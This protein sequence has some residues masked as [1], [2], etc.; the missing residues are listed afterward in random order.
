[1]ALALADRGHAVSLITHP[2]PPGHTPA[3]PSILPTRAGG[4]GHPRIRV[5]DATDRTLPSLH[6]AAGNLAPWLPIYRRAVERLNFIHRSPVIYLPNILGDSYG[7]GAAL[8]ATHPELLRM[9]AWQHTD[10]DYDAALI[11]RYAPCL[12]GI[13]AIDQAHRDTL[14]RR[15]D[16][17]RTLGDRIQCI[18]HGVEVPPAPPPARQPRALLP[19]HLLYTGRIEHKQKRITAL[20]Y[21]SDELDRRAVPHRIT[22]IG[23]GPARGD[24]ARLC[25]ERRSLEL[26]PACSPEQLVEY[27][28]RADA[29]VL[30]S[31]YEG[32]C[33]SR[34]EAAAHGCVPIVTTDRSGAGEGLTD[35]VSA[36]F[37]AA[38]SDDDEPTAARHMADA[39][40]RFLAA[41]AR[42]MAIAAWESARSGFSIEAHATAVARLFRQVAASP[43]RAWPSS[44]SPAFSAV[45]GGAGPVGAGAVTDSGS[46]GP[47]AHARTLEVLKA[48]AERR[49]GG[50]EE[51]EGQER[52]WESGLPGGIALHG[53]GQHTIELAS[54]FARSPVPIVA[55]A[56][57]D[58]ERWGSRLLGWP[59][60]PPKGLAAMGVRDV[61]ISSYI[62]GESIWAKRSVYENAGIRVSR[63]YPA[64]AESR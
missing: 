56:D 52:L 46:L 39:V 54:V 61:V 33:I 19:V 31:R 55:V 11:D 57:D 15:Y 32:L 50:E 30:P 38:K 3:P 35:G 10:S 27:Y 9:V 24:L 28:K 51:V 21:L 22:I 4:S 25:L 41:D 59:V 44:R 17:D 8:A 7:L 43:A 49:N 1:M 14:A 12:S 23:D 47:D 16:S 53:A 45:A 18:P 6:V 40:Q 42:A 5:I 34:I 48:I 2:I 60:V 13:V 36:V 62:H 37:A 26:L 63:I 64:A 58:P 20:A 29:F